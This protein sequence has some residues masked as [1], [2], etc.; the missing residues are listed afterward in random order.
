MTFNPTKQEIVEMLQEV[1]R[2]APSLVRAEAGEG[3]TL[4]GF[5]LVL[6]R[7]EDPADAE[8]KLPLD[9]VPSFTWAYFQLA[10]HYTSSAPRPLIPTLSK[11]YRR[12]GGVME[13]VYTY[14]IEKAQEGKALDWGVAALKA[15][16]FHLRWLEHHG[17]GA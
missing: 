3:G 15:V 5:T 16:L 8:L 1:A 4:R 6:G 13:P 12:A 2:K 14:R 10:D 17:G 11:E 7:E 9:A